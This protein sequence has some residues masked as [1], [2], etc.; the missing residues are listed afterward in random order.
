MP[1]AWAVEASDVTGVAEEVLYVVM[2]NGIAD[3]ADWQTEPERI[4]DFLCSESIK[5]HLNSARW[6]D[7]CVN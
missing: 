1:G 7:G 5:Q 6:M 2:K 3:V 4:K